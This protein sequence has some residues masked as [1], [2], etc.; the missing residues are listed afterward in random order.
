[1]RELST[2]IVNYKPNLRKYPACNVTS[3]SK[4]Y[5][6]NPKKVQRRRPQLGNQEPADDNN[7][8]SIIAGMGKEILILYSVLKNNREVGIGI[9]LEIIK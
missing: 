5:N 6:C 4:P 8:Q 7:N 3:F 2:N 1:M 9:G